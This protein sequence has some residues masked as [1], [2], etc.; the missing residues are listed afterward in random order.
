M[1]LRARVWRHAPDKVGYCFTKWLCKGQRPDGTITRKMWAMAWAIVTCNSNSML[2]CI[3]CYYTGSK[4]FTNN[5]EILIYKYNGLTMSIVI[6]KGTHKI[7][8]KYSNSLMLIAVFF[9]YGVFLILLICI[10]YINRNY[11]VYRYVFIA[12]L[13]LSFIIVLNYL[14]F[15]WVILNL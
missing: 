12:Q 9:S 4:A 8:F 11:S 7:S 5:K 1:M 10:T 13:R 2:H 6:H 14:L 3:Q 15:T